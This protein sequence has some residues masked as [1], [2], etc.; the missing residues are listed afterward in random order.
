ML[1]AEE[2]GLLPGHDER[3]DD[4]AL[5][6]RVCDDVRRRKDLD[7][8]FSNTATRYWFTVDD[9]STAIDRGDVSIGFPALQR[10]PVRPR[11][12]AAA[13]QCP[14]R[15]SRDG[16]RH[17]RTFVRAD[18]VGTPLHQ[19]PRLSVRQLGSIYRTAARTRTRPQRRDAR[20]ET[21][22]FARKASGSYFTPHYLV[23]LILRESVEPLIQ[24]RVDEFARV[25]GL[26]ALVSKPRRDNPSTVKAALR[27]VDRALDTLGRTSSLRVDGS[28]CS[29]TP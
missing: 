12:D 22:V 10:W 9:L 11:P 5:R 13:R 3:Y 15:R 19:L 29:A 17:R 26:S 2:R 16:R 23:H 28:R 27:T 25:G 6:I 7:D 20:R 24:S 1:Y 18:A 14:A 21:N 4:N 8:D